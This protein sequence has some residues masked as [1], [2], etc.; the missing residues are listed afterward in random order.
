MSVL[1][2]PLFQHC[3]VHDWPPFFNKKYMN[4]PIFLDS[5]VKGPIFLTSWYMHIF[6]TQEI[7]R[8]YLSSWYYMNWLWYLC[9]NQQKMGTVNVLKFR[10]KL[11]NFSSCCSKFLKLW[12]AK[13]F[14]VRNF[15]T[16]SL[17]AKTDLAIGCF[18]TPETTK[19]DLHDERVFLFAMCDW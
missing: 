1:I 5:Y 3:Q 10:T 15:R 2:S 19:K 13:K 16:D 4:G 6:F 7:F 12:F 9:N 11:N 8:G 18:R 14:T 17:T